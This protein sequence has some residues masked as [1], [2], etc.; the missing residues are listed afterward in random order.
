M[1]VFLDMTGTITDMES[2]N[3]AIYKLAESIK[4]KFSIEE[5]TQEVLRR[6]E[7]Y[8]KPLMERRHIL[9]VP[10]RRLIVEAT[11]N[12]VDNISG[13]DEMWLEEEYVRVHSRYVKLQRGAMEGLEWIREVAEHMGMITDA[14]TPYTITLLKSLNIERFFDSVITAEDVGVGKPNPRIFM[15]AIKRGNSNKRVYIG[16]SE[17]RD[18]IGAKNVGMMTIKIGGESKNA[19]FVAKNLM[20]ASYILRKL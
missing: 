7:D 16:D 20:E 8:R 10:V 3:Y 6:I 4:T 1:D 9:Y 2:E 5:P 11:K 17:R 13:D 15:E 18:I 12:I 14:D 19:D